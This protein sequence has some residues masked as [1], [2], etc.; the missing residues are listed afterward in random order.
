MLRIA[1]C[2]GHPTKAQESSRNWA[3]GGRI[4]SFLFEMQV[5]SSAQYLSLVWFISL[6]FRKKCCREPIR[7][8]FQ[9][10]RKEARFFDDSLAFE[11]W[12]HV[13]PAQSLLWPRLGDCSTRRR[14]GLPPVIC[15]A[16]VR[17]GAGCLTQLLNLAA[18][19]AAPRS[20][21]GELE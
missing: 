19:L 21:L 9:V 15:G 2:S 18:A 8:M 14:L 13:S 7:Y 3:G 16:P 10:N 11:P 6:V 4:R 12:C 1:R 17:G 20:I 5:S